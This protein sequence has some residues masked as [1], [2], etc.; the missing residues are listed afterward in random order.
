MGYSHTDEYTLAVTKSAI[1]F[2]LHPS[3]LSD[4]DS[5]VCIRSSIFIHYIAEIGAAFHVFD[6]LA[7]ECD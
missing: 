2:G 3:F 1:D 4:A 6:R 5:D 7:V